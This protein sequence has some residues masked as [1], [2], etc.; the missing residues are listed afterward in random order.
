MSFPLPELP[1][2]N[3]L[4]R[5]NNILTPI[6]S[7]DIRASRYTN[8]ATG[9]YVSFAEVRGALEAVISDVGTNMSMASYQLANRLISLATW[10][11]T[12][13]AEIKTLHIASVASAKGGWAQITQA[14]WVFISEEIRIQYEYLRNFSAEL[15]S[16]KQK[17]NGAF[18]IRT[19]LYSQAGRGTFEDTRRRV[20]K[21]KDFDMEMRVLGVADHCPG[22][23]QQAK[24]KWKPLGSLHSIGEEECT[25]NCHCYFVF[26]N[27]ST[28]E[29]MDFY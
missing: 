6:Y 28:G 19:K 16:G 15:Y 27:S 2:P 14:D 29:I 9:Q 13:M 21:S 26:K 12:M 20:F 25:T 1:L 24:L 11:R 4:P 5:V 22:C 10:E 3:R 18:Y 17:I 7:W 23:L 8:R